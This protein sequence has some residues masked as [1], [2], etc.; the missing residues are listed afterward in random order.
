M[1]ISDMRY[2]QP[3]GIWEIQAKTVG[4]RQGQNA[5]GKTVSNHDLDNPRS[6]IDSMLSWVIK[7]GLSDQ[8]IG[9]AVRRFAEV[10][11]IEQMVALVT[12]LRAEI[13]RASTQ[14]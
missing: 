10:S 7:R 5:P 9:Y 6:D 11:T 4:Y 2:V 3:D 12:A 14:R 8:D 13:K 1:P